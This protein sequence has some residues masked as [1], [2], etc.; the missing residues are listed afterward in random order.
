MPFALPQ[1]PLTCEAAGAGGKPYP[2]TPYGECWVDSKASRVKMHDFVALDP[3]ISVGVAKTNRSGIEL[4]TR[5]GL[6]S[7]RV[8]AWPLQVG[9]DPTLCG[10]GAGGFPCTP[11]TW[12]TRVWAAPTVLARPLGSRSRGKCAVGTHFKGFGLQG[13][14]PALCSLLGCLVI[15]GRM[16]AVSLK[17]PHA[18]CAPYHLITFKCSCRA[19][20]G[21]WLSLSTR[22]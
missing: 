7:N 16:S 2:P 19:S 17:L 18:P 3:S 12:R 5:Q 13:T 21:L 22:S 14:E 11:A 9:G 1:T 15:G 8:A 20:Y 6:R 10:K 4:E